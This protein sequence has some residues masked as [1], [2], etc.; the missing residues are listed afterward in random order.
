[1]ITFMQCALGE[2]DENRR[3]AAN[4]TD[5][6]IMGSAPPGR[7]NIVSTAKAELLATELTRSSP[8]ETSPMAADSFSE[9]WSDTKE[10]QVQAHGN[11]VIQDQSNKLATR[12]CET[13]LSTDPDDFENN[14]E[15][16]DFVYSFLG[17]GLRR[18]N[19]YAEK[20]ANQLKNCEQ[21]EQQMMNKWLPKFCEMMQ[22][23]AIGHWRSYK[24]NGMQEWDSSNG[25][26]PNHVQNNFAA[27]IA[28]LKGALENT[29]VD[30]PCPEYRQKVD[31]GAAPALP[32][33]VISKGMRDIHKLTLEK[34]LKDIG[35][36]GYRSLSGYRL[37][38]ENLQNYDEQIRH[39]VD[40][41]EQLFGKWYT[42]ALQER[43]GYPDGINQRR[44][45][46]CHILL[47]MAKELDA[48][49]RP[50][51]GVSYEF[52]WVK[53]MEVYWQRWCQKKPWQ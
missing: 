19:S 6:L 16:N 2:R 4:K 23:K 32:T 10:M 25:M 43:S 3:S 35:K 31:D 30:C 41:A 24:S 7:K 9:S 1:M 5:N 40:K 11:D 49:N 53:H 14:Y 48:T 37:T 38:Q 34:H 29:E 44:Y 15:T 28:W 52:A 17:A 18:V 33:D 22:E 13:F 36:T 26:D 8:L 20:W 39:A 21:E 47:N 51:G 46:R 45:V 50:G 27:M 42:Q 12:D